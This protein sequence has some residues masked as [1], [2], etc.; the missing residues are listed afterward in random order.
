MRFVDAAAIGRT[1]PDSDGPKT[2]RRVAHHINAAGDQIIEGIANAGSRYVIERNIEARPDE[3]GQQLR[4]RGNAAGCVG[5]LPSSGPT[6]MVPEEF[7]RYVLID[8]DQS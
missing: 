8:H 4:R 3:L 1:V 5:E 2:D 6:L 7:L